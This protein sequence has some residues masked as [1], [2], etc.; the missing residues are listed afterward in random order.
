MLNCSICSIT[1][2]FQMWFKYI[3]RH[4][5]SLRSWG[6]YGAALRG[7][8]SQAYSPRNRVLPCSSLQWTRVSHSFGRA[9]GP[10]WVKHVHIRPTQG[11]LW[12]TEITCLLYHLSAVSDLI[13]W[14]SLR[15]KKQTCLQGILVLMMQIKKLRDKSSKLSVDVWMLIIRFYFKMWIKSPPMR[16]HCIIS[17]GGICIES[18]VIVILHTDVHWR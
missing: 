13:I 16:G 5:L 8:F 3:Q 9:W 18:G 15:E 10:G 14:V 6:G 4:T 1:L 11:L 2:C 12:L 17:P 7:A